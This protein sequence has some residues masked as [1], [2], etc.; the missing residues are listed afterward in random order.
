MNME[1]MGK[2]GWQL[3]AGHESLC[4]NILRAKYM[5]GSNYFHALRRSEDS[6]GWEYIIKAHPIVEMA[7]CKLIGNKR[8][9]TIWEDTWVPNFLRFRPHRIGVPQL[10]STV[11]ADFLTQIGQWN[12]AKLRN[13]YN[14]EV[15][16]ASLGIDIHHGVRQVSWIWVHNSNV[17]FST[18]SVYLTLIATRLSEKPCFN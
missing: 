2:W 14:E 17:K 18:K 1:L 5:R 9:K 3:I 13:Y 16:K 7:A 15:V 11:V 6:W 8:H 10:G 4:C 12:V